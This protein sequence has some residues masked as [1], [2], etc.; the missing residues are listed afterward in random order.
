MRW[1][2]SWRY[3]QIYSRTTLSRNQSKGISTWSRFLRVTRDEFRQEIFHGQ[4]PDNS[5]RDQSPSFCSVI[6][7]CC[8]EVAT[9]RDQG[10]FF[11]TVVLYSRNTLGTGRAVPECTCIIGVLLSSPSQTRVADFFL[12][13]VESESTLPRE[14]RLQLGGVVG[15]LRNRLF[16]KMPTTPP[17]LGQG[18]RKW[19]KWT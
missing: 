1:R 2:K 10:F 18:Q 4:G 16:L 7:P 3:L 9:F 6:R 17:C 14:R 15:I 5:H 13:G 8:P 11:W 12:K 19:R